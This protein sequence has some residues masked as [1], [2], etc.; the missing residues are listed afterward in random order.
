MGAYSQSLSCSPLIPNLMIIG[1]PAQYIYIDSNKSPQT[2]SSC[3]AHTYLR[4][5]AHIL[6]YNLVFVC[7]HSGNESL[8]HRLDQQSSTEGSVK[9][10]ANKEDVKRLTAK[11]LTTMESW[12]PSI[13]QTSTQ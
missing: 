7:S 2:E 10:K 8:A 12:L 9:S 13:G 1:Q 5:L 6:L 11:F 4:S 3:S